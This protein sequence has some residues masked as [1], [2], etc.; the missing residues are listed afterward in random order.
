MLFRIHLTKP[1]NIEPVSSNEDI[2][3]EEIDVVW[4]EEDWQDYYGG[5]PHWEVNFN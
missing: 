3:D 4:D 2:Y 1:I 5:D